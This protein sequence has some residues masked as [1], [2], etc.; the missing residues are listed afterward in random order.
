MRY[1][2][3]ALVTLALPNLGQDLWLVSSRGSDEVLLYDDAGTFRGVFA[4]GG[5]LAKPVGL[6]YGPDGHV[7][8][9]KGDSQ[10]VLRYHG[11]TGA[12]LGA[13]VNDP[14]LASPRNLNFGHDGDLYVGDGT[15]DQV[16]R[17][18]GASG[19]FVGVF[20]QHPLLDGPTSLTFGP[21]G[22][23]YVVSVLGDRIV[24][25]HG[26]T[27][28]FLGEFAS[29]GLDGPHD[30]TFG[31]DGALYVTNA[32]A[33]TDKVVRLDGKSGALLG[34]FVTDTELSFPLGLT[35]GP[36][37]HLYVANQ[38]KS[39]LARYDGLTG[40]PLG[41]FVPPG[42]GGLASPAFLAH[43]RPGV[44]ALA[45]PTPPLAGSSSVIAARGL[46][47]TGLSLLVVGTQTGSIPLPGCPGAALGIGDPLLLALGFAD[48]GGLFVVRREVPAALSGT[49]V[50]L[51][52][53]DLSG[54][55][56]TGVL[57]H[58]F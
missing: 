38:G 58:T 30:L 18:D 54:C 52:A 39:S 55:A 7:Y 36:D 45:P 8:V 44:P 33:P 57:H 24:R 25:F 6:T 42:S 41:P 12:F 17:Y 22:H 29:Q 31:P 27:G 56:T 20:A 50:E 10:E 43:R 15:L 2:F 49:S 53:L 23:L 3:L 16:R 9:A 28:A 13:F 48:E 5:G 37:G 51:Q 21:D 34:A 14:G 47:G 26:A 46:R 11:A 40:A 35:F 4:D 1:A 19:A 32:F